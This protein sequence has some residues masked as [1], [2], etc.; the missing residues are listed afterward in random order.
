ML[1]LLFLGLLVFG[2]GFTKTPV[3]SGIYLYDV[4]L[5]AIC[6]LALLKVRRKYQLAHMLFPLVLSL[7]YLVISIIKQYGSEYL[8][9]TIRQY[10]IFIYI[11]IAYFLANYFFR[12]RGSVERA[13]RF[14]VLFSKSSIVIQVIFL[15]FV[16]FTGY[17]NNEVILG[18][19]YVSP[20]AI[21]GTITFG[22]Y[23]LVYMDSKLKSAFLMLIAFLISF[24]FGHASA[25]L[26]LLVVLLYFLFLKI[27]TKQRIIGLALITLSSII[28]FVFPQFRDVNVSWRLEYWGHVLNNVIV[29]N[30]GIF[31][32]G[33][34]VPYSTLEFGTAIYNEYGSNVLVNDYN[35]LSRWLVAPHNS[36]LTLAFHIGMVP[37]LFLFYPIRKIVPLSFQDR[38]KTKELKFL[39]I[40]IL[41][42]MV[43]ASF[44]VILELPHSSLY[45]WLVFF[46]L[47][48]SLKFNKPGT[49]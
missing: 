17:T 47:S 32:N 44:N 34:G 39:M 14:I 36:F 43:W 41:G 8:P 5:V 49:Q 24:S 48:F 22:A 28:L 1:A 31:G 15:L 45:F 13:T 30:Y 23:A 35:P 26:A 3:S 20:I 4:A 40:S 11:W 7:G 38:E 6:A 46:T 19:N 2:K 25:F 33:F 12:S 16:F 42:L 9:L 27:S 10:A 21:L 18:H 37:F 29:S